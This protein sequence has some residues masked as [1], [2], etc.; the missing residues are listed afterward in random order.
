MLTSV[1]NSP[2]DQMSHASNSLFMPNYNKID[3]KIDS[4]EQCED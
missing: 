4:N 1:D 2:T 3:S